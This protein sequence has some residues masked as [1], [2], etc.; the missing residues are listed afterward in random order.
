MRSNADIVHRCTEILS[1]AISHI[2]VNNAFDHRWRNQGGRGGHTPP[3]PTPPP[4][5]RFQNICFRGPP[6]SAP[7]ITQYWLEI[8][9]M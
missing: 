1:Q 2:D 7:E 5:P 8:I 9:L 4:P 3:P 6:D